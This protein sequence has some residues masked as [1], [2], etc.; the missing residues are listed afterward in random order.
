[1]MV[2][3]QSEY[4]MPQRYIIHC[5]DNITEIWMLLN[6]SNIEGLLY[7]NNSLRAQIKQFNI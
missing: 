2:D 7:M 3:E 1:M 5:V 6:K 4:L